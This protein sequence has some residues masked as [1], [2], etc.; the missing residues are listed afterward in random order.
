MISTFGP[1]LMIAS[2]MV[3]LCFGKATEE[4]ENQQGDLWREVLIV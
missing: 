1:F 2:F 3:K 4:L